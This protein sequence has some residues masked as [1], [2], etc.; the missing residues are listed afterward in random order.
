MERPNN[1]GET[2]IKGFAFHSDIHT[3]L[4]ATDEDDIYITMTERILEKNGS[5]PIDG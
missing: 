3:N 1:L 5:M 4:N 2:S